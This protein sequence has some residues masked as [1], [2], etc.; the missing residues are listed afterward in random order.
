M[1]EIVYDELF[2]EI[3]DVCIIICLFWGSQLEC[4]DW[5]ERVIGRQ[6]PGNDIHAVL[7]DGCVLC[8]LLNVMFSGVIRIIHPPG[9]P[10]YELRDVCS[11]FFFLPSPFPY[12][13]FFFSRSCNRAFFSFVMIIIMM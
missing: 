3:Y 12:L 9:S 6:L 1:K 11:H 7:M 2:H 4:W 10:A 5:I 8:E 13:R